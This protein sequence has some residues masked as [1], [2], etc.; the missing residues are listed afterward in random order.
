MTP[1][2]PHSEPES[3]EPGSGND[4]SSNADS[5]GF[6]GKRL[7]CSLEELPGASYN[8]SLNI[9]SNTVSCLK[10]KCLGTHFTDHHGITIIFVS[11]LSLGTNDELGS[12]PYFEYISSRERAQ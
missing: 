5:N 11:M 12:G 6:R 8:V 2:P 9:E 10:S 7:S 3:T 4:D 1:I